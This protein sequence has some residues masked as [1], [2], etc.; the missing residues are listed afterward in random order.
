MIHYK[1]LEEVELIRQNCLMVGDT[2]AEIA[3]LIKP[4]VT[5]LQL[6]TAAEKFIRSNGAIPSFKNYKGFPFASCISVNDAVNRLPIPHTS[7]TGMCIKTLL[8]CGSV[9]TLKL[10]TP[11]DLGCL[12]A[13]KLDSLASVLVEAT[14]TQTGI[15]VS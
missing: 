1:T 12:L 4:G 10:N 6:D 11:R 2:I 8:T 9:R 7:S 15:P 3:K 13:T 5:T 14:P